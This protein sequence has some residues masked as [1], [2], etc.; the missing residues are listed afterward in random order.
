ME[1]KLYGRFSK[2]KGFTLIELLVVI[3]IIAILAAMLLP[4]L[5]RARERARAAACMNN[6][7]QIGIL[8]LMYAESN[9]YR[10]PLSPNNY[11]LPERDLVDWADILVY[12]GYVTTNYSKWLADT[13]HYSALRNIKLFQ[14]PTRHPKY[15]D[16]G[17]LGYG[18][19]PDVAGGRKI[20]IMPGD[21]ILMADGYHK[22]I[23]IHLC[24]TNWGV[25]MKH[26]GGANYLYRDG[27]VEWDDYFY[28]YYDWASYAKPWR[29]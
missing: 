23:S 16:Y 2:E 10:C 17:Y 28:D 15:T 26:S 22:G 9:D 27:H 7:K 6:L 11:Y 4:A 20:D 8:I 29:W 1:W 13:W 19:S 18:L 3:A 25:Y 12:T 21:K 24:N 14:C 5:S